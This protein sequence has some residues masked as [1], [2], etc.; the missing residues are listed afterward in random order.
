MVVNGHLI[1]EDSAICSNTSIGT[2]FPRGAGVYAKGSLLVIRNSTVAENSFLAP[3]TATTQG[4]GIFVDLSRMT[5]INSTVTGNEAIVGSAIAADPATLGSTMSNCTV[6]Q[7]TGRFSPVCISGQGLRVRN[8]IIANN[9]S[10]GAP[11]AE[12]VGT[13]NSLGH[14]LIGR[15][16]LAFSMGVSGDLSGTPMAPIDPLLGPLTDNG[17]R[18]R[19]HALLPGSPALDSANGTVFEPV[20]QRGLPRIRGSGPDM[21]SIE[22]TR[23]GIEFCNGDGGNQLGCVACPCGNETSPGISGGCLNSSGVGAQID[24][25]G[26]PSVTMPPTAGVSLTVSMTGGPSAAFVVLLSGSS[27]APTN[28]G[29]P[30][31]GSFYGSQAMLYDGLRCAALELRRAGARTTD[32]AGVIGSTNPAWGQGP[33]GAMELTAGFAPGQSRYFQAVFRD[34]P[35]AVCMRGL[36][37]SQAIGITFSP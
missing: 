30:C 25:F 34:D 32:P 23:V 3:G 16:G 31:F 8:S 11:V 36:N 17:G 10:T 15:G 26:S 28:P 35:L 4:G 9:F 21:G 37:T 12:A 1:I 27:V 6:T 18:G 13:I 22:G 7:N 33:T 29:N 19:T 2:Y 24:A 20:D 14:N 5:L